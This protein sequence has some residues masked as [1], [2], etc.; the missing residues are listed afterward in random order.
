MHEWSPELVVDEALARRLI[1]TSFPDVD[2]GRLTLLAQGW[3]NALWIGDDGWAFRFPQREL[4]VRGLE[5]E[6]EVLPRLAPLLP[7]PIPGPILLGAASGDY[8]WPYFGFRLLPGRE[9][10]V[11]ALDDDARV[12]L[13][14]PLAAF[15]R[16]LHDLGTRAVAN[17]ELPLDPLGRGD[18]AV[19]VPR[20]RQRLVELEQM[21]L[22]PAAE[23]FE[24]LLAAAIAL[25]PSRETVLVHGDLHA[26]HVLVDP[27]GAP[28]GVIDWG[29]LCL[30]DPSVD[31]SIIWSLLSPP[32]RRA[33]EATY[34]PIDD[35]THVRARMLAVHLCATLAAYGRVEA[36]PALERESLAGLE[37]AAAG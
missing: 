16:A 18:P 37:R 25:P 32:A 24:P 12:R 30:A 15:L 20:I 14:R 19:R 35:A 4:G 13:A 28:T 22:G 10:A 36:L 2:P 23:A 9:A 7:L 5:R 26:R 27:D 29:D 34:G 6:I 8:P 21:G 3:D 1:A 11:A 17:L 33:F 31:L